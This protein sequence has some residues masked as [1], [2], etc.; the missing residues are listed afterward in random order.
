MSGEF[1]NRRA[2]LQTALGL[3]AIA[4]LPGRALARD[5]AKIATTALNDRLTLLS[6]AGGNVLALASDEG[7]LLV[8]AGAPAYTRAL[9][10][11]LRQ[12]PGG[13]RVHTVI[14]THWHLEQTGGNDAF[15]KAGATIIAHAKALQRMSTDQY[16]PWEDRYLKAR[17]KEAWPTRSFYTTGELKA[18]SESIEYGYLL[19]A[20]TDGDLYVHFRDSNVL[21]VGD[22][23]SPQLDPQLAWY[24]GGWVGGRVDAL[25]KLLKTGNEQTRIVAATGGVISRAELKT[26]CD[27]L[28]TVFDRLSE[29]VRKGFTTE[30]MQKAKLLDGLPRTWA[31]PD[32][33]IYDAHKGMWAHHNTLSHQIV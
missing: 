17:S 4:A 31:N 11:A 6:G 29:A 3:A 19:E 7:L 25:T 28:V 14:N 22:A 8:D 12:L 9:Q 32:K 18:G 2:V 15:G 13:K 20:H 26:E 24:E 16:V 27:A 30:D 33:F 10:G 5:A 21:A 1:S 23:A